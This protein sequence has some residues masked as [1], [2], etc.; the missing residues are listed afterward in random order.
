MNTPDIELANKI[1]KDLEDKSL[2]ELMIR[3]PRLSGGH[4]LKRKDSGF[5]VY[6]LFNAGELPHYSV[7]VLNN[8][9][10]DADRLPISYE[11]KKI[12]YNA[13][14][15]TYEVMLKEHETKQVETANFSY[16]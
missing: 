2:W 3:H 6:G 14:R 15:P 8:P 4:Y 9:E 1:A 10:R 5:I 12:I 7:E 11:A 16:P 13:G